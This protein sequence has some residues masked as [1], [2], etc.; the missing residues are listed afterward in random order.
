MGGGNDESGS[1]D[2]ATPGGLCA[3]IRFAE[4]KVTGM[5]LYS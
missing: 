4:S 2:A 5:E 3:G 1:E